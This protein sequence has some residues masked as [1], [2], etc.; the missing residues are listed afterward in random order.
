[1]K[2][3]S[4]QKIAT[5]ES[6]YYLQ[7]QIC[8]A[9]NEQGYFTKINIGQSHFKCHIGIK[10]SE[11]DKSYL[12]GTILD[13]NAHYNN[14]DL[15][16]QYL[17][18]PNILKNFGWNILQVYAKDWLENRSK[19]LKLIINKIDGKTDDEILE[20]ENISNTETLLNQR[21]ELATTKHNNLVENFNSPINTNT[22]RLLLE[23]SNTNKFWQITQNKIS[24]IIEFGKVNTNGQKIIKSFETEDLAT[25]E[26]KRLIE[27][28]KKKNYKITE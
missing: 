7:Q 10:K 3:L 17:L 23:E 6:I 21:I 15:I 16:E 8:E 27:Q 1:M 14:T 28:K 4:I 24:L 26:M 12:L 13:D 20:T 9:L 19:V 5:V 25:K 11:K 22:I 2:T 18:K